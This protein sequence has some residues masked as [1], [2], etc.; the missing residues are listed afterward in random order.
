MEEQILDML[1]KIQKIQD[2]ILIYQKGIKQDV[3]EI[4]KEQMQYK[5]ELNARFEFLKEN[6][7]KQHNEIMDLNYKLHL[8]KTLD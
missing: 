6:L 7:Y 5:Q 2:E 8:F 1:L 4:I 3:I